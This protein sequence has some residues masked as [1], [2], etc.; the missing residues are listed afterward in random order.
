MKNWRNQFDYFSFKRHPECSKF[1]YLSTREYYIMVI[2]F[3]IGRILSITQEVHE[4]KI[5]FG[6]FAFIL[7]LLPRR[8]NGERKWYYTKNIEWYF[9]KNFIVAI[10]R[11]RLNLFIVLLVS[12]QI[13]TKKVYYL[14]VFFSDAWVLIVKMTDSIKLYIWWRCER[15][16]LI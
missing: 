12:I 14:V 4:R 10:E 7:K 6:V 16:L 3:K 5:C 9:R 11:R 1:P 2:I 8:S 13:Q 15:Y